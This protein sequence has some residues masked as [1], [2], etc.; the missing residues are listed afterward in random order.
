LRII[1][2]IKIFTSFL[3]LKQQKK[4]E[5]IRQN[6]KNQKN[7]PKSK[8][9]RKNFKTKTTYPLKSIDLLVV[10]P[11]GSPIDKLCLLASLDAL[12]CFGDE[13]G[14]RILFQKKLRNPD[15]SA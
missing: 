6:L 7:S 8:K 1:S 11:V 12:F 14:K 2:K 13:E 4:S 15:W 10:N 5:K 3:N 9:K